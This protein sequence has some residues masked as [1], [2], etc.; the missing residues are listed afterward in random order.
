MKPLKTIQQ[1]LRRVPVF[2]KALRLVWRPSQ[3]IHRHLYFDGPFRVE[4]EPGTAF[5]MINYGYEIENDLFWRGFAQGWEANALKVW[6]E[7]VRE[8]DWIV[9]IGANT[10]LYALSAQAMRPAAKILAFEPSARVREKL[11]RN[12]ALNGFSARALECAISDTTGTAEFFDFPGEHQYSA[13]L[14][15][16]SGGGVRIEVP[17]A[18]LDDVL[19]AEGF[20]RV[21]AIK[22]DVEKH[23]P[24]ALRGMRRTL[25]THRPLLL[26][27]ILKHGMPPVEAALDGLGYAFWKIPEARMGRAYNYLV[28]PPEKLEAIRRRLP[29]L[30]DQPPA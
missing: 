18:R 24:A 26:V 23:E 11:V 25:E 3:R 6:R 22:L 12:I 29:A 20:E 30:A 8:A 14:E 27:E 10:G 2:H 15:A 9:D 1:V 17:V 28:A 16:S 4:V 21:D 5:R 19:A 13:S 7:M